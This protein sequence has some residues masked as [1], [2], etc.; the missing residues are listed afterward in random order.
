MSP[1]PRETCHESGADRVTERKHD[2]RDRPGRVLR[3]LRGRR[4][5][6]DNDVRLETH[7]VG[8]ERWKLFATTVKILDRDGASM[9]I[10]EAA[11]GLEERAESCR[12]RLRG[13]RVERQETQ[14]RNLR[15]R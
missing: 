2:D 1:W 12:R 15:L 4:G 8:G 3:R 10:A 9:D 7:A 5:G 11:Q 13:S 14:E 6:H